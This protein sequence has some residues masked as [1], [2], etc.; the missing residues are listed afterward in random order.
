MTITVNYQPLNTMHFGAV[1]ALGNQV[2]GDNYLTMESLQQ[3]AKA[4]Y[5]QNI[6]ASWVAVQ[7]ERLVGFRIT[8]AAGN[9]EV[10]QWCTPQAWHIAAHKICYFKCNT[11]S[12]DCRGLGIGSE[13]LRRS[14]NSVKQQGSEAGLAH[15]WLASPGNSAFK[16]FSKAGGKL[17][18]KH[19]NKWRE[20]YTDFDCPICGSSCACVAG[21]MLLTFD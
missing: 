4:S 8:L 1:M 13:L 21:E 15:I 5:V 18:K 20:L 6:N 12:E 19:P 3:Y 17:I 2:H 7:G 9:W 16:Y 11:V 10:D 14:I